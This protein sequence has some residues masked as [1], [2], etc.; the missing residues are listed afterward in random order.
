MRYRM[1]R[2]YVMCGMVLGMLL[3]QAVRQGPAAQTAGPDSVP[4]DCRDMPWK[5]NIKNDPTKG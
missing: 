4:A 2:A 3:L 1:V 5:R